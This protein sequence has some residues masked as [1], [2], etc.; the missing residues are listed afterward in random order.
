[1]KHMKEHHDSAKEEID[2]HYRL[3]DEEMKSIIQ[4]C[5]ELRNTFKQD[6]TQSDI[7]TLIEEINDWEKKSIEKIKQRAEELRKNL[8]ATNIRLL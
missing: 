7:K 8:E 2:E 4:Q 6:I 5:N 3:I 1:M